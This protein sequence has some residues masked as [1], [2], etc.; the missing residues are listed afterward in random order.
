[1]ILFS[2]GSG[3]TATMFSLRLHE[4]QH[5]FSLSNIATVMDVGGKLKSRHEVIP[6]HFRQINVQLVRYTKNTYIIYIY[7]NIKV[8][9]H[10]TSTT[11]MPLKFGFCDAIHCDQLIGKSGPCIIQLEHNGEFLFLFC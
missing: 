5:P 10:S 2:Y 9:G 11:S 1:M 6:F 4:G 7:N 8:D 3:L